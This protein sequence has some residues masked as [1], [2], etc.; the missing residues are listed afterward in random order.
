M[1]CS[2]FAVFDAVFK[3]RSTLHM[4]YV[5]LQIRRKRS[6]A[7]VYRKPYVCRLSLRLVSPRLL[8]FF[9]LLIAAVLSMVPLA[10]QSKTSKSCDDYELK[11]GLR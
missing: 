10:E 8:V 6:L 3:L 4:K 2:A 9:A 11:E 5:G 1:V 7:S